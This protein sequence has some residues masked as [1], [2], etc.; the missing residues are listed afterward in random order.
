MYPDLCDRLATAVRLAGVTFRTEHPPA[1]ARSA[2]TGAL[3]PFGTGGAR[4][5]TATDRPTSVAYRMKL[6]GTGLEVFAWGLRSPYGLAW[7]PDGRLYA[8]DNGYDERGSRPVAGA[9]DCVWVAREGRFP[10]L[11]G[12]GAADRSEV[13][14]RGRFAS[15][16]PDVGASDVRAAPVEAFFPC[17]SG[18]ARGF[19]ERGV[20]FPGP[21]L[22]RSVRRSGPDHRPR[23]AIGFHG[24]ARGSAYRRGRAVFPRE[25]GPPRS[26][27]VRVRRDGRPAPPGGRR[28]S[29]DGK[30]MFVVDMGAMTALPASVRVI[31]TREGTAFVW[32]I[33]PSRVAGLR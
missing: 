20:R 29:P 22:R 28:L 6:D 11:R 16:V 8:T 26:G 13:P 25:A 30:S 4:E 24:A 32:R 14:L 19:D 1:R 23:A 5:V 10:G 17:G 18:K 27:G 12:R 33:R 15:W 9:P 7:G 21:V 3:Q 31:K 2:T